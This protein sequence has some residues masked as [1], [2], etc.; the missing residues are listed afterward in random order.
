VFDSRSNQRKPGA[1][2]LSLD[3]VPGESPYNQLGES[4]EDNH[5]GVYFEINHAAQDSGHYEAP[6]RDTGSGQHPLTLYTWQTG[7][8][9]PGHAYQNSEHVVC[10]CLGVMKV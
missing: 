8:T 1:D 4:T 6:V 7:T 5:S 3:V 9:D 10:T 2:Y